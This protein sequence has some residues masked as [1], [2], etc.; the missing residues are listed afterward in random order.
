[1]LEARQVHTHNVRV[2]GDMWAGV[3]R[4]LLAVPVLCVSKCRTARCFPPIDVDAKL[5][6]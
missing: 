4:P 3:D 2:E 5:E 1:M 6:R